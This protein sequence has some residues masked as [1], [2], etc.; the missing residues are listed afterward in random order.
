MD[1]ILSLLGFSGVLVGF[2]EGVCGNNGSANREPIQVLIDQEGGW[3]GRQGASPEASAQS[4]AAD[5]AGA[6][7][8]NRLCWLPDAAHRRHEGQ[9]NARG[10]VP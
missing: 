1:V 7:T 9:G 5:E 10:C 6:V 8:R 2:G 4:S 3:L